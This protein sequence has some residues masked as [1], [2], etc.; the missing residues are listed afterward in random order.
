MPKLFIKKAVALQKERGPNIPL[1]SYIKSIT[2]IAGKRRSVSLEVI[3]VT[4]TE[5]YEQAKKLH[6][7]FNMLGNI[8]I[9]IPVNPAIS[10]ESNN[11][12]DGLK[13]I[14]RLSAERI[15]TNATLI[16]S[17]EQA[18]LAAKAGATY[19]SPFAGRIDDYLRSGVGVDFGYADYYPSI[20]M[21][22]GND[23][24][25]LHDK[26]IMSGVELVR[27]C[28]NIIRRHKLKT[29]VIAASIRNARQ[30]RECATVGAHIATI[31]FNV[32][33]EMI[34]H[35]KTFEGV[36]KFSADVVEEYKELF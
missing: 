13:V 23:R 14:R 4:E 15:K 8:A 11:H 29:A 3:G 24:Q 19:V 2:E 28:L 35:P 7:K 26:G 34:V 25:L 5:M 31:P 30:V 6:D 33:K 1:H 20:G 16:F 12:Y 18:L 10:K 17:P 32:L 21:L 22:H 36:K 27:S 9:K